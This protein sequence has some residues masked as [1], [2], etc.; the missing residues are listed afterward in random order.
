ML[1]SLIPRVWNILRVS[2]ETTPLVTVRIVRLVLNMIQL[3]GVARSIT[4][5]LGLLICSVVVLL[6]FIS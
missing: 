4:V 1:T 6:R 2:M 3:Q 5:L